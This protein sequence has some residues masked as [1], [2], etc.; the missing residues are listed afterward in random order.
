MLDVLLALRI[1]GLQVDSTGV[2]EVQLTSL[3]NGW[4]LTHD[5]LCCS[6]NNHIRNAI[7][8]TDNAFTDNDPSDEGA[9]HADRSVNKLADR[10]TNDSN[11]EDDEEEEE[12]E[13]EEEWGC[14]EECRT[15]LRVCLSH[16]Q[17]PLPTSQTLTLAYTCTFGSAVSPVLGGNMLDPFG[18]WEERLLKE[19]SVDPN[20]LVRIPFT[21]S[22][23]VSMDNP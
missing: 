17:D 22:W 23:P 8:G 13:E 2:F 14:K 5:G 3:I 18:T 21:F 10:D 6:P 15:F 12:E 19:R 4:G 1:I 9:N 20:T 11:H 7:A 16:L